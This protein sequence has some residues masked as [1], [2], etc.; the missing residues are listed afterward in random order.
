MED[1]LTNGTTLV[2]SIA[3]FLGWIMLFG[4]PGEQSKILLKVRCSVCCFHEHCDGRKPASYLRFNGF[5]LI[6]PCPPGN[7]AYACIVTRFRGR[8]SV[9]RHS[10]HSW[11]NWRH[12]QGLAQTLF[13]LPVSPWKQSGFHLL[14]PKPLKHSPVNLAKQV[15]AEAP[16]RQGNYSR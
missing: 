2:F 5:P 16:I 4:W 7:P 10:L 12:L 13:S 3:T 14:T 11:Q 8:R 1:A 15:Y 9:Q 6:K